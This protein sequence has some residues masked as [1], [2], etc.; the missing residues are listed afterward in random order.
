MLWAWTGLFWLWIKNKGRKN[1]AQL[2]IEYPHYEQTGVD[3]LWNV[4]L[5]FLIITVIYAAVFIIVL[6]WSIIMEIKHF[7]VK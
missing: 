5:V 4:F 3:I 1:F 6:L 2:K 7:F